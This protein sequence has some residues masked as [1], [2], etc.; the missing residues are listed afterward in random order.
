MFNQLDD[1]GL[2]V[3]L[4]PR[5]GHWVFPSFV[6]RVLVAF[7]WEGMQRELPVMSSNIPRI[8]LRL[9]VIISLFR[10]STTQ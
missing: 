2:G 9:A 7:W 3:C 8:S 6:E 4:Q 10:P 5:T 1:A